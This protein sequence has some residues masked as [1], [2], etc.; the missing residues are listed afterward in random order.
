MMPFNEDMQDWRNVVIANRFLK[1][2]D[3]RSTQKRINNE[4]FENKEEFDKVRQEFNGYRKELSR[5]NPNME[6]FAKYRVLMDELIKSDRFRKYQEFHAMDKE[7]NKMFEAFKENGSEE[8]EEQMFILKESM[9]EVA[10]SK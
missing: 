6:E 3:E 5:L 9:N 4:Y 10:R 2:A 1:N 8:L 7:L